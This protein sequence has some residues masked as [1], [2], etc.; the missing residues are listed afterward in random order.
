MTKKSEVISA[1]RQ[2]VR[3]ARV[4][5]ATAKTPED[6]TAAEAL[7]AESNGKYRA[8]V[9]VP[10]RALVSIRNGTPL[11]DQLEPE[12]QRLLAN[13]VLR[14]RAIAQLRKLQSTL[15]MADEACSQNQ[16]VLARRFIGDVI[17]ALAYQ[18]ACTRDAPVK[19]PKDRRKK[20]T[21][22]AA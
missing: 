13:Q 14:G 8:E 10:E 21:A 12:T 4:L 20:E 9:G 16:P 18:E 6:K 1:L 22:N 2:A 19:Q 17:A 7:L 11:G 5:V 15:R 3:E